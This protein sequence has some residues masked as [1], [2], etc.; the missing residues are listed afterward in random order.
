[1]L[2]KEERH[3]N[4]ILKIF[5]WLEKREQLLKQADK[6]MYDEVASINAIL[7]N[8]TYGVSQ[9]IKDWPLQD[10][11]ARPGGWWRISLK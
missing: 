8:Y 9:K 1:M 11:W 6:M 5:R 7:A 10:A 2:L 3:Q 4:Y